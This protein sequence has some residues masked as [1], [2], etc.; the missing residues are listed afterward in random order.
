[1]EDHAGALR[2]HSPTIQDSELKGQGPQ[3]EENSKEKGI[4]KNVE[5][6]CIY[7]FQINNN[8]MLHFPF[9]LLYV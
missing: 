7:F 8:K 2:R 1:M 3:Q 5:V 4:T 6:V 9:Y